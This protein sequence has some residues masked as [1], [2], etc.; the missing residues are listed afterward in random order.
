MR[1]AV[2][3]VLDKDREISETAREFG[4]TRTGLSANVNKERKKIEAAQARAAE[5]VGKVVVPPQG[6]NEVRRVPP[7]KE[8]VEHY[9]GH[10]E[11]MD[12][13]VHHPVPDF[14][15]EMM[16]AIDDPLNKKI[17]I[18][19]PPFHAKSTVCTF[20]SSL[21]AIVKNPNIQ[22]I[23]ISKAQDLAKAFIGQVS[24]HLSDPDAYLPG[25]NL[26]D[27]WGPFR[28]G[29]DMWNT[30]RLMVASRRSAEK[31][32]TIQALGYGG[33][34]YGKRAHRIVFDDVADQQNQLSVLS[35]QKML[36]WYQ[37]TARSRVGAT[38]GQIVWVGTR[39][40]PGDIYTELVK[41]PKFKVIK[42]PLITNDLLEET[43]WPDHLPYHG[44]AER[45]GAVDLRNSM[46]I[47]D[48]QLI[49]QQDDA[50]GAGASF[51]AEMLEPC[52]DRTR[53]RGMYDPRW[54]IIGGFD[55]A[56]AGKWAGY[57]AF[58]VYG[59]D[60][61]TQKRFLIDLEN[62]RS[63]KSP[64]AIDMLFKL[65]DAYGISEWRIEDN[66]MNAQV[67][68]NS[69]EIQQ[70]MVNRGVRVA[71]HTTGKNKWDPQ[72]G[73]ESM[74][75]LFLQEMISIP[76]MGETD[77]NKFRLLTDQLIGFPMMETS[78][79]VMAFWFAE[80]GARDWSMRQHVPMFNS[81]QKVPAH[82]RARRRVFDLN[83]G[84]VRKVSLAEQEGRQFYKNP[85]GNERM[86]VGRTTPH[87][88]VD[89][90]PEVPDEVQFVNVQGGRRPRPKNWR[91]PTP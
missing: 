21:R 79:L 67:Y 84:S 61:S 47:P 31:D 80:L 89:Y 43:L 42:Y 18:N 28:E 2:R 33:Q 1:E 53:S 64:D 12:C 10:L 60:P 45:D 52:L 7:L 29:S 41:D 48:F 68:Q 23:V 75:P 27:D 91:Q 3:Q 38:N 69:R 63:M 24:Q 78:D 49:Y 37:G 15:V 83:T 16:E 44:T 51:T 88:E 19:T 66:A 20:W 17:L 30:Q 8:F 55:P 58:V 39:V 65:T 46:S 90:S 70:G 59:V 13:N 50:P 54:K 40:Q 9:F 4:I 71:S 14:H 56:G 73:V 74:A 11:C 5:A 76:W 72:W 25:R 85:L 36:S 77:R 22:I 26:I 6:I 57:S 35:V 81:R 34:I 86:V 32:P 87:E 62:H 82:V